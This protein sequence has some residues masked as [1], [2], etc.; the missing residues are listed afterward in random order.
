MDNGALKMEAIPWV[1]VIRAEPGGTDAPV[2][3][4]FSGVT[5]FDVVHVEFLIP[6]AQR[7]LETAQE[8]ARRVAQFAVPMITGMAVVADEAD[9]KHTREPAPS[10]GGEG[11]PLFVGLAPNMT[12]EE[13][14]QWMRKRWREAHAVSNMRFSATPD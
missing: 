13:F 2:S 6:Y 5:S 4:R 3:Q 7:I 14:D 11:P 10:L 1:R 12:N 8:V 9:E